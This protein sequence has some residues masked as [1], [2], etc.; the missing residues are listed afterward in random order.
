MVE[1]LLQFT[2]HRIAPFANAVKPSVIVHGDNVYVIVPK[3][4]KWK[5]GLVFNSLA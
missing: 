1:E 3:L 5:Q 2:H 4:V